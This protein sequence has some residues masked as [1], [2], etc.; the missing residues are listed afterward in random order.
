MEQLIIPATKETPLINFDGRNGSFSIAGKSYPENVSI[1]YK[2]I[3]EYIELYKSNPQEK[4]TVE[5]NWLYYNTSTAKNIIKIIMLLKDVGKEFEVK[6]IC[7]KDFD[8]IIDKGKEI[9][10]VL[11]VNLNIIIT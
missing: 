5:F 3:F 6:W 7:K 11:D 9:K 10:E 8:I 2:P 4:T 1:F